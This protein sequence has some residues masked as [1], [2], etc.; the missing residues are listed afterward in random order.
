MIS[1]IN[2]K[3]RN[4]LQENILKLN[5]L[6]LPAFEF[7][8]IRKADQPYDYLI[9]LILNKL[10]SF[11]VTLENNLLCNDIH[12]SVAA[13]RYMYE[14]YIKVLCIFSETGSSLKLKDFYSNK[15]T[16]IQDWLDEIDTEMLP[17]K[18]LDTHKEHYARLSR[19]AHPN[20]DSLNMHYGKSNDQIFNFLV[21]NIKLTL[22]LQ[23][24]I[25]ILFTKKAAVDSFKKLDV[26]ELN[27]I[28]S[29]IDDKKARNIRSRANTTRRR[30]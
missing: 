30:M 1:T 23:V 26:I 10:Y 6:L 5:E 19:I 9:S 2:L 16:T 21:P 7:K 14:L 8:E 3:R 25:L 18:F 24:N 27:Q 17:L 11:N 12:Q 29:N 4:L 15:R 22:W 20:I 13:Y 28:L